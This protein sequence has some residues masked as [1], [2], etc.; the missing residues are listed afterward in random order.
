[1]AILL[2]EITKP[3]KKDNL[4]SLYSDIEE[5]ASPKR[6]L[7]LNF[8]YTSTVAQLINSGFIKSENYVIPIHGSANS[9]KNPITFGYGDDTAEEYREL[10]LA[11]E[12]ELLR[13]IKSFQFQNNTKIL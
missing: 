4:L 3:L 5:N 9:V 8:N 11:N 12:N 2:D 7:Y 1:M 6:I 10:E 13:K